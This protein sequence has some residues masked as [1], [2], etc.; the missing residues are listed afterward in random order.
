M[1]AQTTARPEPYVWVSWITKLLAGET[2]CVW[3]AWLRA[4]Y[5]TARVPNHFD[6]GTW[7]MDHTALLRAERSGTGDGRVY[8]VTFRADDGQ[9]GT[10]EGTVTVCVPHDQ[11]PG[12]VC[13]DQGSLVDSTSTSCAAGGT[14]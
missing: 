12:H 10:C 4:H 13:G 2:S 1:H 6:L 3:S 11:R 14:P 8:H 7:Q 5:E 9:G